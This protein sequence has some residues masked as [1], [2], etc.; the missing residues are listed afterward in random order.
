MNG[1]R[2]VGSR[3]D[4]LTLAYRASLAP[5]LVDELRLQARLAVEH[6]CKVAV[7]WG[8][9]FGAM[10]KCRSDAVAWKLDNDRYRVA[11]ALDAPGAVHVVNAPDDPKLGAEPGWTTEITYSGASLLEKPFADVER[12]AHALA[13]AMGRVYETRTRRVDLS[14]DVAGFELESKMGNRLVKRA[15]SKW[16]EFPWTSKDRFTARELLEDERVSAQVH[17]L[18]KVTGIVVAPGNKLMMRLYDKRAHL[19]ALGDPKKTIA[20]ESEWRRNGWDDGRRMCLLEPRAH[21]GAVAIDGAEAEA[22]PVVRI[23]FQLRGDVWAELGG[24]NPLRCFD[25]SSCPVRRDRAGKMQVDARWD[26][27]TVR[28]D[29]LA[30]MIDRVWLRCLEWVWM[31][32]DERARTRGTREKEHPLWTLLRD[33]TFVR[34]AT[35]VHGRAAKRRGSS[36]EQYYGCLLSFLGAAGG[37]RRHDMV[38]RDELASMSDEDALKRLYLEVSRLSVRGAFAMV[39]HYLGRWGPS[40]RNT[41]EHMGI[42]H[43]GAAARFED[44][45]DV[46]VW[47]SEKEKH[48][49]ERE[50]FARLQSA[51]AVLLRAT[52]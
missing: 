8:P 44:P 5:D 11:I 7:A 1:L 17:W 34:R 16:V 48:V 6:E 2:V 52:A 10:A 19:K 40:A 43:D 25:P 50:R 42:V 32:P 15:R 27:A 21:D 18:K 36:A 49:A 35:A 46:V 22:E 29:S 41:L 31:L 13:G 24:R 14:A 9:L 3:V 37:L 47:L 45:P 23:E 28:F 51:S 20:E 12:E 26:V 4:W 38:H 33:V 30:S 39:D